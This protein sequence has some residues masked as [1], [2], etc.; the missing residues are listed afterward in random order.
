MTNAIPERHLLLGRERLVTFQNGA[1][2]KRDKETL[3]LLLFFL[4]VELL[5]PELILSQ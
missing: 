2:S 5:V 4:L 3:I 1:S